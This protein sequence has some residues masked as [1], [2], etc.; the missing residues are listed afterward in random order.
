MICFKSLLKTICVVF[1]LAIMAYA[2]GNIKG[3]VVDANYKEPLPGANVYI[4]ETS[5]GAA[6]DI[7]GLYRINGVPEGSYILSVAYI[8]YKS[9]QVAIDIKDG[10]TQTV[11]IEVEPDV[12]EGEAITITAQAEG[13]V[14]AINQ[15]VNS[16]TIV[17]VVSEEKIQELPDANAAEAIGRLPGV[18]ITRTGGEANKVHIRGMQAKF[19]SIT[20]DGVRIAGTDT[21][22][23][24]VDLSTLS[25][26]SLAGIELYKAITSDM[27]GD[28]L[29]G[30][31]NLV[32]KKAPEERQIK[33]KISGNYN[34]LT[35]SANQYD[36]SAH[37]GERFFNNILGVQ[38]SG[39][40]EKKIRSEENINANWV[41]DVY[42][43]PKYYR[44]NDFT[45]QYT[46]ENRT[47]NGFSALFDI[48]T[49]DEGT[50]RI[51]NVYGGTKR[52]FLIQ[53][54]DYPT[55]G[56]NDGDGS[57][58]YRQREQN[59]NIFNS[60]IH[61]DNHLFGLGLNWGVSFAE[62]KSEFPFDYQMTF[63]EKGPLI[64][65]HPTNY[66]DPKQVTRLI[67][68]FARNDFSGANLY[69]AQFQK[70][71][72]YQKE[73]TAYF[74]LSQNY[75]LTGSISGIVK[76][77]A[78]YRVTDRSNITGQGFTPYY[79][80]KWKPN[81][82]IINGDDTLNVPKDFS[83]SYFEDWYNAGDRFI[84]LDKFLTDV[85]TRDV[86]GDYRLTPLILKERLKQWQKLNKNGVD[87]SAG[88]TPTFLQN[89]VWD[90]PLA[91]INDYD[92]TENVSAFY[93][94]NTLKIGQQLTFI[95]GLRTEHEYNDYAS[96][97]MKSPSSGFPPNPDVLFDTTSAAQQTIFLPNFHLAYSPNDYLKI[98]LATYK[99][100]ARPD[101]NMR[102]DR[103]TAGRG[104]ASSANNYLATVGNIKLKT[105]QAW[106]YELNTS[107]YSNN[108]GLISV[109]VFY[110]EIKDMYHVL[111]QFGTTGDSILQ[112][113]N[114]DWASEMGNRGYQLTLPYNSDKPTKV[115]GL[116]FEHQ[117]NFHFLPGYLKNIVLSYNASVVRS[118]TYAFGARL[119]S[120]Y[121]T[122]PGLP[123]GVWDVKNV[124]EEKKNKLEGQPEFFG[125]IALGYDIGGFSGRISVFHQAGYNNSLSATFQ[126]YQKYKEFTRV[127]IALK[128]RILDN[129]SVF[130]NVNN[131][132]NVEEGVN[133]YV[134]K[135][136]KTLFLNSH[137]Y[138][139][140]IDFGISG[141]F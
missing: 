135:Y 102:I 109:S 130:L 7:N 52:D 12:I 10:E 2:Q 104:A 21:T 129:Y 120:V 122:V 15:Q 81:E 133:R 67:I 43:K 3:I 17:N 74:N 42:D 71:D 80:D 25:Q 39:N 65:G 47:R 68:P 23:R 111:S 57:Y 119:D 16:N 92:I 37:Y 125:N 40:L 45:V 106:N 58:I 114:I 29:A 121:V 112:Y 63:R 9:K 72:N 140:T 128:Q 76:A 83:G 26:S 124:L 30:S 87:P 38:L 54:R 27:D 13:Q 136:D 1:T 116:E 14:A 118:E 132:T 59:I 113:F 60:S 35:E 51:N 134:S 32:T 110:K 20:I 46:D 117:I 126:T 90:N 96:F 56:Q 103:Y 84:S 5:L 28:A 4:Q 33:A 82:L 50:I 98:R 99:A 94:M 100:L 88:T 105:A 78:K 79:L 139:M 69:W 53:N 91:R 11:N 89:E 61:G 64:P 19:S 22:D 49:P 8:G 55:P 66:Y 93:I 107:V 131:L 95:S 34:N 6:T 137:K 127:D 77:G 62:S 41:F 115:W 18:S 70:Q 24:A 141:E 44:V 36:F 123:G 86:Y 85:K 108:I 101:F 138:G 97:Y 48:N 73:R 31:I 75:N